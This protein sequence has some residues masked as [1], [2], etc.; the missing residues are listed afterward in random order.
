MKATRTS[1]RWRGAVF[2]ADRAGDSGDVAARLLLGIAPDHHQ[3]GGGGTR[4][5]VG[6]VL[7]CLVDAADRERCLITLSSTAA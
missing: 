4:L 7:A 5:T 3:P 1:G 6:D 2:V